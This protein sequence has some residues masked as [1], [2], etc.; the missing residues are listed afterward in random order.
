MPNS[1]PKLDLTQVE[2]AIR[3][4][5]YMVT[6]KNPGFT[7]MST[8]VPGKNE[9]YNRYVMFT[10]KIRNDATN[11]IICY[12]TYRSKLPSRE[13]APTF[14]SYEILND[15]YVSLNKIHVD[16]SDGTFGRKNIR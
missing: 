13:E 10:H 4:I 7:I 8:C 11:E 2:E 15:S 12:I 14:S 16:T 6:R 5:R 1:K 9:R 3:A